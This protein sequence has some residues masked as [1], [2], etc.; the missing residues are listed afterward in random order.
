MISQ[1]PNIYFFEQLTIYSTPVRCIIQFSCSVY[2]LFMVKQHTLIKIVRK[3]NV[4]F[5][6]MFP[7]IFDREKNTCFSSKCFQILLSKWANHSPILTIWRRK[8]R[9]FLQIFLLFLSVHTA[10]CLSSVLAFGL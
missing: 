10:Q 4:F 8:N 7:N 3:I 2:H 1:L 6:Q 5:L 9:I